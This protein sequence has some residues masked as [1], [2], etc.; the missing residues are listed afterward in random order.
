MSGPA[1]KHDA[2]K[3]R[4]DL[5]APEFIFGTAEILKFGIEK[6]DVRNWE[7]GVSW[8]RCFAA[9][10]RHMWAWW[11]G[12]KNDAESGKPHLWHACCCLM[13]LVAY[14]ARQIGTDDRRLPVDNV[15]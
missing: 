8:G 1:R 5:I 12:E 4:I 15:S 11:A 6:Y 3:A 13:F 2:E 10:M 9:L 7:K 14:E